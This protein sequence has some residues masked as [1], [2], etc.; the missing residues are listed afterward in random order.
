MGVNLCFLS[1]W[2]LLLETMA[3]ATLGVGDCYKGQQQLLQA[4]AICYNQ[5]RTLL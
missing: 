1:Q 2:R 4:A 3:A 5:R